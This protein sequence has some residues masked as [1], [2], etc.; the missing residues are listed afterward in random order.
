RRSRRTQRRFRSVVVE[1]LEARR[2]LD[3]SGTLTLD[4]GNGVDETSGQV[5]F[6]VTF[7]GSFPGGFS[8]TY[9]TSND[10][11]WAGTDY[12]AKSGSLSFS[13]TDGEMQKIWVDLIDLSL[14]EHTERFNLTLGAVT[15][16]GPGTITVE[17]PTTDYA[18]IW[19][20]DQAIISITAVP[21]SAAEGNAGS[22]HVVNFIISSDKPLG[23]TVSVDFST[24]SFGSALASDGDFVADSGYRTLSG[25]LTATVA[26]TVNGDA[27]TEL[28]E[29][30]EVWFDNLQTNGLDVVFASGDDWDSARHTIL[31]DDFATITITVASLTVNEGA[32]TATI[33]AQLLGEVDHPI[34]VLMWTDAGTASGAAGDYNAT[35]ATLTFS[36][37][38]NETKAYSVTI[39][40]DNIVEAALETFDVKMAIIDAGGRDVRVGRQ[41][42]TV[43]IEDDDAAQISISDVSANEGT[44]PTGWTEFVFMLTLTKPVDTAITIDYYTVAV[45]ATGTGNLDYIHVNPPITITIPAMTTSVPIIIYVRPDSNVEP[46]ETFK[47]MLANLAAPG[48]N[49]TIT[50]DE[51]IGTIWND[52]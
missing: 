49:V 20:D 23:A 32:G 17:G 12:V 30:F 43:N 48:R 8:V 19:D 52:D 27:K 40:N 9:S 10:T 25:T 29:G 3:G 51:G 46:T 50:D 6:D 21:G 36:G 18:E 4:G 1:A 26:I 34:E 42:A 31:N 45:S 33:Q 44:S 38:N 11:A 28:N 15:P 7:A 24:N 41:S 35:P 5:Y 39:N 22:Q 13:G 16:N 2:V 37:A 14:V 47:L